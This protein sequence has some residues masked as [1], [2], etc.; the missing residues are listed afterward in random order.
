MHFHLSSLLSGNQQK[1]PI[2]ILRFFLVLGEFEVRL[3][4]LTLQMELDVTLLRSA[5]LVISVQL[6]GRTVSQ[7]SE[8]PSVGA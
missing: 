3:C 7:N 1:Q 5:L 8:N 4:W 6:Q 2:G